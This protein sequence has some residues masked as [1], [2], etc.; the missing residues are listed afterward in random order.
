M[1]GTRCLR[2]MLAFVLLS[3]C[4]NPG[5]AGRG[6]AHRYKR[7][8]SSPEKETELTRLV[9]R[10]TTV[11]LGRDGAFDVAHQLPRVPPTDFERSRSLPT[12]RS[13]QPSRPTSH[14]GIA[15]AVQD[16]RP[17]SHWR[18]QRLRWLLRAK[19]GGIASSGPVCSTCYDA[20]SA[21]SRLRPAVAETRSGDRRLC[22]GSE[23]IV[24]LAAPRMPDLQLLC[25][26]CL[27]LFCASV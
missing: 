18:L 1:S 14:N 21:D 19:H 5:L 10:A 6:V 25:A 8:A 11:R 22:S 17:T 12:V 13:P 27:W 15:D 7:W 4:Q 2:A 9:V 16:L 20:E 24:F 26:S 23:E 3:R